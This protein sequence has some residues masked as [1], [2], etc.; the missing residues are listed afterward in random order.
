MQKYQFVV[1]LLGNLYTDFYKWNTS[2]LL[3]CYKDLIDLHQNIILLFVCTKLHIFPQFK[4]WKK[5]FFEYEFNILNYIILY[6][7]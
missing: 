4:F 3:Y 5:S 1:F 7:Q 2:R 6:V